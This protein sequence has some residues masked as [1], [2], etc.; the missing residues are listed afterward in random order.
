M[1]V[2]GKYLKDKLGN[3]FSPIVSAN[4]VYDAQGNKFANVIEDIDALLDTINGEE[5]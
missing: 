4:T 5:I 2:N 1:N 3:I